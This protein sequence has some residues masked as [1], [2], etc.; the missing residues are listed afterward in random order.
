MQP[1]L[2]VRLWDPPMRLASYSLLLLLGMIVTLASGWALARRQGLP[3]QRVPLCLLLMAASA[4]VGGRLFYA[5]TH[6]E[7]F[8][9][10]PG[11]LWSLDLR[12]LTMFGTL[13]LAMVTGLLAARWLSLDV[14]RLADALS[15]GLGL[16]IAIARVGCFLAGCCFGR[17]TSVPWAVTFPLGSN[18]HAYQIATNLNVLFTGVQP[19][20]PTQLYESAAALFG[21]ALA[22][23]LLRSK[24]APGSD[25]LAFLAWYAGFRTANEFMRAPSLGS[26]APPW[27]FPA[28]YG[29]VA[30]AAA[31]LLI[32]RR[33]AGSSQLADACA[34]A[35]SSSCTPNPATSPIVEPLGLEVNPMNVPAQYCEYCGKPLSA[36]ARFCGRCGRPVAPPAPTG[37]PSSVAQPIRQPSPVSVQAET[38]LGVIP[39]ATRRKGILGRTNFT[40]VLTNMRI[41]FATLTSQMMKENVRRAKE[42]ARQQ[43]K[44]FFGQWGSMF[45]ANVGQHYLAMQPQGILSEHPDNFFVM[46][47]QVR[48]VK[49]MQ[50]GDEDQSRVEYHMH[51]ETTAEKIKLVF[52]QMDERSTRQLLQQVLG[53]VVR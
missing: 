6:R 9:R 11:L 15:P 41:L 36:Q 24:A 26:S 46:N 40:L 14:V 42:A 30:L 16:G 43:G 21:A 29:F 7:L 10:E 51:L 22:V 20:H 50:R 8:L 27:F 2:T 18:A 19:V 23:W 5:A 32:H 48:K 39:Y 47:Q 31:A 45:G 13:V 44:G 3:G 17:I 53:N 34:Q 49:I 1:I 33:H 12:H 4:P 28:L 52:N 38:V 35:T 25:F 37:K